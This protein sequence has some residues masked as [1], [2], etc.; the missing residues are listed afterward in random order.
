METVTIPLDRLR[1]L[2]E[3]AANSIAMHSARRTAARGQFAHPGDPMGHLLC[4][5]WRV[6][7]SLPPLIVSAFI[8]TFDDELE[9]MEVT[10]PIGSE[11]IIRSLPLAINE[12]AY[13]DVDVPAMLIRIQDES[14]NYL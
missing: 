11:G 10:L 2:C 9:R 5:T 13:P 6:D 14:P 1:I 3:M 7:E 4:T 12:A 8:R